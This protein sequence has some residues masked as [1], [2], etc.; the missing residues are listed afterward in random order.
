M[1]PAEKALHAVR[2]QLQ[3]ELVQT[4]AAAGQAA[5]H[6]ART[7]H[8]VTGLT[9]RCD[10]AVIELRSVMR[11][12]QVNPALLE[13]MQRLYRIERLALGNSQARLVV[14]QQREQQLR[15]ALADLRNRDRTLERALQVERRKAL[16]KLQSLEIIRADDL[17]VQQQAWRQMQ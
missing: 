17:W 9:Q 3:F 14:A 6:S 7:Q 15:A 12:A 11:R 10:A 5:L 1:T 2:I 8:E 13:A 16:R 4:G